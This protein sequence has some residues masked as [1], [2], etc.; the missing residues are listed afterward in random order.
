[1]KKSFCVCLLS[2]VSLSANLAFA[3]K[4][5]TAKNKEFQKGNKKNKDEKNSEN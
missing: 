5:N 1:M 2:L 3:E 4:S